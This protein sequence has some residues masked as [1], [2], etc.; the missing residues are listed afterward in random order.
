MELYSMQILVE[1]RSDDHALATPAP[2]VYHSADAPW[3]RHP[4]PIH[5]PF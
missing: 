2:P 5:V 3:Y 4:A 1:P